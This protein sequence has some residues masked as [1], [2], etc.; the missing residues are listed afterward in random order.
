VAYSPFQSR[1][2]LEKALLRSFVAG[3]TWPTDRASLTA[4]A[5]MGLSR[6][7][8]AE[9]FAVDA[10]EVTKLLDALPRAGRRS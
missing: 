8:I 1:S 5:D 7:Q 10:Q 9:C 4:L 6:E 2:G 3:A